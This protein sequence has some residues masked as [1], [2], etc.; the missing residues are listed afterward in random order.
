[1]S[2]RIEYDGR[3]GKYEVRRE[4]NILPILVLFAAAFLFVALCTQPQWVEKLR[5][6][7][8]PGEDGV[9]IQAFHNM[10]DD[11]RSGASVGE[12]LEVFCRFVIHGE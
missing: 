10:T 1:M 2:Y 7:L 9:T 12:A 5:N 4:R 6:L 3:E 8:I 11:L